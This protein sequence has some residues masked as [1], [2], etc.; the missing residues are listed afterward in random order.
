MSSDVTIRTSDAMASRFVR[1]LVQ[2]GTNDE[3]AR[4]VREATQ[5]LTIESA[6]LRSHFQQYRVNSVDPL[7]DLLRDM[8]H[9][10]PHR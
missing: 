1:W 5:K 6:A 2:R 3:I 7:R 8:D 10:G 9:R 4:Q